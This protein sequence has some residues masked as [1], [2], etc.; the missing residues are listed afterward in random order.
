MRACYVSVLRTWETTLHAI[1][2]EEARAEGHQSIHMALRA[3]GEKDRPLIAIEFELQRRHIPRLLSSMV[4]AGKQGAYV[5]NP[6]RAMADEPEAVDAVTQKAITEEAWKAGA[7]LEEE[8]RAVVEE[9]PHE[10]AIEV[11]KVEARR[12]YIDIRDELR[13]YERW[14]SPEAKARQVQV[15]NRKLERPYVAAAA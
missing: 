4:V 5:D 9:L 15:I 12:R 1:T 11:L 13:A 10:V 8:H 14:A 3:L 2:L 7:R 6:A